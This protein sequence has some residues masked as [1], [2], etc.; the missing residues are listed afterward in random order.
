MSYSFDFGGLLA[1]RTVRENL[2]LPISYH[3][4]MDMNE[5]QELINDWAKRFRFFHQLDERPAHVSG[6][7]RKLVCVLRAILVRP[8]ILLMDDPFTGLDPKTRT[9]FLA[10]LTE[11]RKRG[12]STSV[13]FTSN[14]E[15]W[16][17]RLCTNEVWVGTRRS[18]VAV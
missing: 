6:G 4:L 14:D 11:E 3:Q 9:E 2:L 5:A 15:D 8:Q 1:N 7:L 18:G 17:R 12:A 16:A 13:L 10:L